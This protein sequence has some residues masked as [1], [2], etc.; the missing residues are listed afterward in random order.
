MHQIGQHFK[1]SVNSSSLSG[2][3]VF[4]DEDIPAD[5]FVET[6]PGILIPIEILNACYYIVKADGLNPKDLVLDQYG[7]GWPDNK[8]CIPM[9]W[10]G[11]YNHSDNPSAEFFYRHE[12][13][14]LSIRSLM[15]I[16]SGEEITVYYGDHWW[17]MKP[18][19][20]KL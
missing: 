3:G 10:I 17:A 5:E 15:P 4:A 11:L 14:L 16:K 7:L 9:G 18:F 2:W 20:Q 12:S 1:I 8:V 13:G 19:L 6:A